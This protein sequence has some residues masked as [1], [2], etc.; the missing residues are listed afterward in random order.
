MDTADTKWIENWSTGIK[1][2]SRSEIARTWLCMYV[3]SVAQQELGLGLAQPNIKSLL[4]QNR[5][6]KWE[7]G[8]EEVRPLVQS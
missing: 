1:A 2:N 8:D 6:L 5:G 3:C 4:L 7:V